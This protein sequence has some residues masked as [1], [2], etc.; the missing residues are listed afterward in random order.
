MSSD[1][2]LEECYQ[3]VKRETQPPI[4]HLPGYGYNAAKLHEA[5]YDS[6]ITAVVFIRMSYKVAGSKAKLELVET[7]DWDETPAQASPVQASPVQASSGPVTQGAFDAAA[8]VSRVGTRNPYGV[9]AP[10]T[11]RIGSPA[12]RVAISNYLI[13]SFSTRTLLDQ[14]DEDFEL[15]QD[16][17]LLP[18]NRPCTP[19]TWPNIPLAGPPGSSHASSSLHAAIGPP[20]DDGPGSV[21]PLS[22]TNKPPHRDASASVSVPTEEENGRVPDWDTVFWKRF[23]NKIRFGQA[24]IMHLGFPFRG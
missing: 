14:E 7:D 6:Y 11:P 10:P 23:G 20:I 9:L 8:V 16:E 24:G 2:T 5:G 1:E 18:I 15:L 19:P 21:N 13:G 4:R 12:S 22:H 17:P 3:S